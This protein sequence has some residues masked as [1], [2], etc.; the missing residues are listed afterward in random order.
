[1]LFGWWKDVDNSAAHGEFTAPLHKVDTDVRRVHQ[2]LA[3]LGELDLRP[4]REPYRTKVG[5]TLDLRLQ[6]AAD[7]SD[8]DLRWRLLG[9]PG[10]P[11]QDGQPAT[12]RV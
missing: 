11:A 10:E 8:D 4:D 3:E 1:M 5:E 9:A 7:R 6:D 12:N 2:G